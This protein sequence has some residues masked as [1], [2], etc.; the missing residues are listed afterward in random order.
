MAVSSRALYVGASPHMHSLALTLAAA[1]AAGT[2]PARACLALYHGMGVAPD[3]PAARRCL[4]SALAAPC[5]GR[6]ADLA[7]AELAVMDLD[8]Q[9]GPADPARASA[10]L[11]GCAED[12]TPYDLRRAFASR[13]PT[14]VFDLCREITQ[15]S[16]AAYRDMEAH[17]VA[18][19]KG[20]GAGS[21]ASC[22]LIKQRGR[23]LEVH[24]PEDAADATA[25]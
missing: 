13:V 18:L 1:L 14:G 21:S 7:R 15:G 25:E 20:D 9:G 17:W 12:R 16:W 23:M 6:P 5:D 3:L 10:L 19:W 11:Q 8:A 22:S 2:A 4:E 24:E